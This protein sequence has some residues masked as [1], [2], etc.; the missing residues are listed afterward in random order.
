M[1][2]GGGLRRVPLRTDENMRAGLVLGICPR[3]IRRSPGLNLEDMA[4]FMGGKMAERV[5]QAACA[6]AEVY[7]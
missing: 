4:S 2:A 7:I 3:L 1:P 5:K 6:F